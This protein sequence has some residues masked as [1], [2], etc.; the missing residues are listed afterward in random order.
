LPPNVR[1]IALVDI[2]SVL[3]I[4]ALAGWADRRADAQKRAAHRPSA[5]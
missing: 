5:R 3:A 1:A 4:A 2:V